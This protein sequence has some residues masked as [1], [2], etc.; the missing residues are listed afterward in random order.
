M[1][2]KV[3]FHFFDKTMLQRIEFAHDLV[4]EVPT[5][6]RIMRYNASPAMS[7]GADALGA[8]PSR[9]TARRNG[10]IRSIT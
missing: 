7:R 9:M 10:G 4:G 1:V 5:L 8:T 2:R 6:R 3:A